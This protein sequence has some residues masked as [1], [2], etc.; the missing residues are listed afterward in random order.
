[1]MRTRK[2]F[3]KLF[4]KYRKPPNDENTK[5]LYKTFWKV[6]KVALAATINKAFYGRELSIPQ[7]KPIFKLT[8]KN[9]N[10]KDLS[11][12]RD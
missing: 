6:S 12:T 4:G 10:K 5:E 11:K 1:M 8:E 3:I 2:S 9:T 7:R